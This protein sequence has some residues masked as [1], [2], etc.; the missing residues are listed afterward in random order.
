MVWAGSTTIFQN[1]ARKPLLLLFFFKRSPKYLSI[2][3]VAKRRIEK[4]KS[5]NIQPT[6]SNSGTRL[7][8][9]WNTSL[10]EG[11]CACVYITR[12]LKERGEALCLVFFSS[13]SSFPSDAQVYLQLD[14]YFCF[15]SL[16]SLFFYFHSL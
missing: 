3:L 2:Y 6:R 13:S 7:L 4:I 11:W 5:F 1:P 16:F 8:E 10:R 9:V 12:R 14:I 15:P